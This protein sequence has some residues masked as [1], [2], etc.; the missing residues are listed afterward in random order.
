M[1]R[2][3]SG[4]IFEK[5]NTGIKF[6]EN[7]SG[8]RRVPCGQTDRHDEAKSRFSQFCESQ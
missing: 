6:H 4:H 7:P 8:L 3:C 1:K 5:K 2:G